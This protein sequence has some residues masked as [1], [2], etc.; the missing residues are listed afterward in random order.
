[1]GGAIGLFHAP[2]T[3]PVGPC[4]ASAPG[5]AVA[6]MLLTDDLGSLYRRLKAAAVPFVNEPHTYDMGRGQGPTG[7]FTVFDPNCVRVA[8]AQIERETLEQSERR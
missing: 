3:K 7:T 1:M 6:I 5:G 8:F 4:A 2:G